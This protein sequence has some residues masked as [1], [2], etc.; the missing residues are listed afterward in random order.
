MKKIIITLA[1]L[2][3]LTAGAFGQTYDPESDFTVEVIDNGR[4]VQI[5]G[6]VGNKTVV[7]IPPRIRN[8][9]VT[10]IRAAFREKNLISVT[11]PN[12]VT[13]IG[14]YT[15][16]D[17]QLTNVIIPN[18]ITSIGT[19]AFYNNQLTNVIIPNSVTSIGSGTF[20]RN[21][22]TSITIPNSVTSI[23]NY[24]FDS[25]QLTSVTI[26]NSVTSIRSY[27]FGNNPLTR[28]IIPADVT[29]VSDAFGDIV[30]ING[31]LIG[32][33]YN[34]KGKKAFHYENG[35]AANLLL[36]TNNPKQADLMFGAAVFQEIQVLR[37]LGDTAAVNRHEAVLQYITGRGNATRAEIETFYRNNV[38]GLVSQVV[39]EQL[40]RLRNEDRRINPSTNALSNVKNA[41]TEFMLAP[42]EATYRN[43]LLTYR[44][45]A[46]DG[47]LVLGYSIGQ[48]NTEI[49]GAVVNNRILTGR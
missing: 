11:I 14:N 25:N 39:D 35:F 3:A 7:N 43:L 24:A 44:R 48:I 19:G 18:S 42:S 33:L 2:S 4:A 29:I 32:D 15:F 12:S 38:R 36:P 31:V 5:T 10:V 37:F 46:G 16:R 26:P 6:Y 1:L 13:S 30:D 27:T 47:A 9:P 8:L 23:G 49:Y 22:L 34:S 41:I 20:Q 28:I 40:A 21:Q 45:D 17:N